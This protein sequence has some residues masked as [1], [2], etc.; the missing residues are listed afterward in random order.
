[1]MSSSFALRDVSWKYHVGSLLQWIQD[2]QVELN[3]QIIWR[4][5]SDPFLWWFQTMLLL[6]KFSYSQKDFLNLKV[7][8]KKWSNY[9]SYP[10]SN[11]VNKNTM[12]L[13]CEQLKVYWKWQEILR[14]NTLMSLNLLC[15]LNPL[16][17]Q[18]FLNF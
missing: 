17:T 7:Y 1:M 11:L 14:D 5:C 9:I 18:I 2:M 10:L 16:E 3:S 15:W 6:H 12:T 8:H 13:V 4:L